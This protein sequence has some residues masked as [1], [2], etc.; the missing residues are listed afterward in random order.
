M[1]ISKK[2]LIILVAS[3]I[4]IALIVYHI[5]NNKYA[6]TYKDPIW[7][8]RRKMYDD[9]YT[10]SHGSIYGNCNQP[11]TMFSGLNENFKAY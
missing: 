7:L 9:Y 10:R 3:A 8:N 4:V 6:E 5:Q 11:W 1:K 2:T